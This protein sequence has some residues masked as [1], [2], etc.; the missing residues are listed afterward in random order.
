MDY[1]LLIHEIYWGYIPL[2]RES[3]RPKT[4]LD[5]RMMSWKLLCTT[6]TVP[7]ST[8]DAQWGGGW[9]G[10]WWD[11]CPEMYHTE[12][13]SQKLRWNPNMKI[14]KMNLVLERRDFQV[15][16]CSPLLVIK[17]DHQDGMTFFLLRGSAS[18][19]HLHFPLLQLVLEG[20]AS[21]EISNVL[22]LPI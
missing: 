10:W 4:H 18:A 5:R 7:K 15:L 20:G 3:C 9:A 8:P 16:G 13:H 21:Q 17:S 2:G 6:P 22:Q 11:D 14:W 19:H 12:I 1:N